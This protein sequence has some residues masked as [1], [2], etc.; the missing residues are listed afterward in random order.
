MHYHDTSSFRQGRPISLHITRE[1]VPVVNVVVFYSSPLAG[2][3]SDT[4]SLE[5][6]YDCNAKVH[7]NYIFTR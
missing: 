5:V 2:L 7:H 6:E 3:V 4:V 1:Y